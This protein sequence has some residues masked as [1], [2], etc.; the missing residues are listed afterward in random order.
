MSRKRFSFA[1]TLLLAGAVAFMKPGLSA[2]QHG[3]G[4]VGPPRM[5]PYIKNPYSMNPYMSGNPYPSGNSDAGSLLMSPG[6]GGAPAAAPG[7]AYGGMG[8]GQPQTGERPRIEPATLFGLPAENGH[9]QWPLGLRILAPANETKALRGQLEVV[10]SFVAMQAAEGQVNSAFIDEG[11]EAVREF[12]QLLRPCEG[13][14]ADVT[15]T[16][17]MRFLNRAQRGL[18]RIKEAAGRDAYP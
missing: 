1:G 6:T 13:T 16:D 8:S 3:G 7:N 12:R 4:H 17:A 10:L 9:L 18:T 14:M 15:Y 11:L 2:A 5:T